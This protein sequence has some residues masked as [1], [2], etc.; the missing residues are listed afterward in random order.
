MKKVLR[1]KHWYI[2]LKMASFPVHMLNETKRLG[3]LSA[4]VGI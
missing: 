3:I 1:G 2:G 4:N